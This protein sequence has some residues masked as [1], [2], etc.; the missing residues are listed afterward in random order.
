[1]NE[2]KKFGSRWHAMISIADV[3]SGDVIEYHANGYRCRRVK[4]V[5]KA[6]IRVASVKYCGAVVKTRTK[7]PRGDV[8]AAWSK[9]KEAA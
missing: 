2:R 5:T 8:I 1:M 9:R 4:S 6:S 3:E 7:I